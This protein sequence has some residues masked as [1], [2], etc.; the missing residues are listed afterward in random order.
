MYASN[1]YHQSLGKQ[2]VQRRVDL[3]IVPVELRQTTQWAM[4]ER[5]ATLLRTNQSL[6]TCRNLLMNHGLHFS[7]N[8]TQPYTVR[9]GRQD[10]RVT[11][12]QYIPPK[13]PWNRV[14]LSIRHDARAKPAD[15]K[16]DVKVVVCVTVSIALQKVVLFPFIVCVSRKRFL[17]FDLG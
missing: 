16:V 11:D 8:R 4:N 13:K 6:L 2:I 1:R 9:Q 14:K 12:Q 7:T 17:Q 5:V 10:K 15:V 3:V